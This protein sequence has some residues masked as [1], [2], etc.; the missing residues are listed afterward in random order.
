LH[1]NKE[2]PIMPKINISLSQETLDEMDRVGREEKL[3]RSE[4]LRR[5]FTAYVELLALQKEEEEK[6]QAIAGA[7]KIQDEV[8]RLLGDADLSGDLRVWREK[9]R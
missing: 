6:R 4:L 2:E 1:L 3:T 8:R 9:R 7:V 5:A